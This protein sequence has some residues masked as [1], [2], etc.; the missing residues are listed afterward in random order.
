MGT[1][2]TNRQGVSRRGVPCSYRNH[3][4]RRERRIG[5]PDASVREDV[6]AINNAGNLHSLVTG[7]EA[8]YAIAGA[9]CRLARTAIVVFA[10]PW[11]RPRSRF[12]NRWPWQLPTIYGPRHYL[13]GGTLLLHLFRDRSALG[14]AIRIFERDAR[15]TDTAYPDHDWTHSRWSYGCNAARIAGDRGVPD[16]G[17]P[18]GKFGIGTAWIPVSRADRYRFRCA[19]HCNRIEPQRHARLSADHEFSGF[20]D[21]LPL[22][23]SVSSGSSSP[24][25]GNHYHSRSTLLWRRWYALC[26]DWPNPLWRPDRSPCLVCCWQPFAVSRRMA[27]F[28]NRDLTLGFY[29]TE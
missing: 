21:L 2:G 11:I 10:G 28:Q 20:A 3:H 13:H 6:E 17:L 25:A 22:R 18:P 9:D 16:R 26:A 15:R 4:S 27:L 12:P 19:G 14:P 1:K 8:I 23:C 24:C 5:G 29:L 7:T